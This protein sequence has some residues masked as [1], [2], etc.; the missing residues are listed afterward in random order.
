MD[1]EILI[2]VDR[3]ILLLDAYNPGPNKRGLTH[4]R[5]SERLIDN[6]DG[7]AVEREVVEDSRMMLLKIL[8]KF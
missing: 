1:L 3:Q 8:N 6:E 2:L 5:K 7:K 4:I